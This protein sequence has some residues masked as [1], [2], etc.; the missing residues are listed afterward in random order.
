MINPY[1]VEQ[2]RNKSSHYY[3]FTIL[4]KISKK[5]NEKIEKASKDGYYH[6][7]II[8]REH[9]AREPKEL[10]NIINIIEQK[11]LEAGY[12]DIDIYWTISNN[13]TNLIKYIIKIYW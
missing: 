11:Y 5:I 2:A 10:D 1:P 6:T 9:C 12:E 7:V 13:C 4:D 8:Y 3:L